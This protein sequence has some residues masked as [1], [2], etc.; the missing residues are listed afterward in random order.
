MIQPDYLLHAMPMDDKTSKL[1]AILQAATAG[2]LWTSET[3]APLDVISWQEQAKEL[4]SERL[5]ELTHH[6]S[7]TSVATLNVDD[8]FSAAT[9]EQDWFGD[10]ETAIA[11]NYRTLVVLL[12]ENLHDLKVY[13]V[14]EV[15]IDLY[16]V[17]Q[18]DAGDLV[19]IATQA[20]E[21]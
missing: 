17:G 13:R 12:K 9:E 14:G 20:T 15:T 8:F 5:L 6:A 18:T 3:D 10:E 2:L 4:T 11:A 19:G 21:T 1:I 16:I 7:D